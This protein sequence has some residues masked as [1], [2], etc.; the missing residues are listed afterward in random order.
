MA[1]DL[2]AA[3]D[4]LLRAVCAPVAPGQDVSELVAEMFEIMD[5]DQGVGLAAPQ[6]GVPLRVI[7]VR[8]AS[9]CMAIVNPVIVKAPG[10]IVTSIGE[11]CLSFPGRRVNVKRSKR[12]LVEGF[13]GHWTPVGI[14]ARNLL[15]FILQHEIDHLD[16]VTIV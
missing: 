3:T 10:K 12:V 13:D 8:Y 11:G 6:I 2:V 7:T 14:D 16:G 15:A 5:R 4:P 9:T 1:R